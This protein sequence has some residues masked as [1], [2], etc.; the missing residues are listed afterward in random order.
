VN[1]EDGC[2]RCGPVSVGLDGAWAGANSGDSYFAVTVAAGDRYVCAYGNMG[3]LRYGMSDEP[4]YMVRLTELNAK[5]GAVYYFETASDPGAIFLRE[6]A[7]DEGKF[8]VSQSSLAI[9]PAQKR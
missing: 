8:L 9:W 1:N 2:P 4:R 7:P 6:I 3:Y 5:P